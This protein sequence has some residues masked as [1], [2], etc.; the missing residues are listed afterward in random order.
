MQ[1]GAHVEKPAAVDA[2]TTAAR[3]ALDAWVREMVAW[4]FDPASGCPFWLDYAKKL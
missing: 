3:E 2:G 4:H 1:H